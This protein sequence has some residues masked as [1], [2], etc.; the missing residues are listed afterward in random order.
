MAD[1]KKVIVSGSNPHINHITSSGNLSASG[2]IFAELTENINL[3][4]V[5]VYNNATGQLEQKELN[6]VQTNEAPNLFLLD[7]DNSDVI[8]TP[9]FKL[10]FDSGSLT[11]P[12][13][14]PK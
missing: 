13:T 1:W 3:T 11:Q 8:T 9:E 14:A 12:I 7:V 5:V 6:L 10:S 2:N 4:R